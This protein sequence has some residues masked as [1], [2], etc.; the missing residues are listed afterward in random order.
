MPLA[1]T[2]SKQLCC[3]GVKNPK[4]KPIQKFLELIFILYFTLFFRG[5]KLFNLSTLNQILFYKLPF[6]LRPA[7]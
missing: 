4:L 2:E 3:L 7:G 5:T 1:F 6:G